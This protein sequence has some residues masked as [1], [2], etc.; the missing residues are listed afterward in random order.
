M[1]VD[2]RPANIILL[3]TYILDHNNVNVTLYKYINIYNNILH[4]GV[5]IQYTY[6]IMT[7]QI[8]INFV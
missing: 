5:C 3:Q 7:V 8:K 6:M 2:V 1:K 4:V